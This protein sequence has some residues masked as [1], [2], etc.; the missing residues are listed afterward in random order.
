MTAHFSAVFGTSFANSW[1]TILQR[2][3]GASARRRV[4][5]RMGRE[6]EQTS[7]RPR[8]AP[9]AV[10]SRKTRGRAMARD[11]D[12]DDDSDDGDDGGGGI[13]S[14]VGSEVRK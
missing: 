13:G 7:H 4:S 9:S 11:D 12:D 6:T 1:K 14:W 10:M 3:A 8:C 5:E 2:P